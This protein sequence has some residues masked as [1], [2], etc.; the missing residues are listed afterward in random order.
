[1]IDCTIEIPVVTQPKERSSRPASRAIAKGLVKS[2]K[3][4]QKDRFWLMASALYANKTIT[5]IIV[6]RMKKNGE[7]YLSAFHPATVND[8][9]RLNP[10]KGLILLFACSCA[11]SMKS[12]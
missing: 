6:R 4:D 10:Y 11:S 5:S 12:N 9:T 8:V 1:M 2:N 3:Y 7:K